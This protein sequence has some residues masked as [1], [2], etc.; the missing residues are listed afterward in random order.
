LPRWGG[1][2][3]GLPIEP[4]DVGCYVEGLVLGGGVGGGPEGAVEMEPLFD[5]FREADVPVELLG[6]KIF[7]AKDLFAFEHEETP[8]PAVGDFVGGLGGGVRGLGVFL[9]AYEVGQSGDGE[10]KEVVHLRS[11]VEGFERLG[12]GRELGLQG[13]NAV[14][15]EGVLGE[16]REVAAAGQ[17]VGFGALVD[18]GKE[19][20]V[21]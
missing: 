6:S 21:Q 7:V 8:E 11:E 5:G 2:R 19:V 12:R 13:R 9:L 1:P 10:K 16:E 14:F 17:A 3:L 4:T 18:L 15:A 20:L